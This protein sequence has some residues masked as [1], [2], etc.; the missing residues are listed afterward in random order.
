M[1]REFFAELLRLRHGVLP[2]G[3]ALRRLAQT[4]LALDLVFQSVPDALRQAPP[5]KFL[6]GEFVAPWLRR[7][8]SWERSRSPSRGLVQHF[9]FI[10][11]EGAVRAFC[12][13]A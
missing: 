13:I 12:Q 8:E 7:R 10:F 2:V 4:R 3:R 5:A 6:S 9:L 11:G 1:G